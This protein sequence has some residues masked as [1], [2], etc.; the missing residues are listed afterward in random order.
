M[1]LA[2]LLA[3]HCAHAEAPTVL[4]EPNRPHGQER[5]RRTLLFY[6]AVAGGRFDRGGP[7]P[8]GRGLPLHRLLLETCR[9]HLENAK[10]VTRDPLVIARLAKVEASQEYAERMADHVRRRRRAER[11]TDI[12]LRED[13]AQKALATVEALHDDVSR[14]P[15]RPG[16]GQGRGCPSRGLPPT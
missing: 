7:A 10:A 14:E 15:A 8:V 3:A 6:D 4:D 2:A 13:I 1:I 12:A 9:R 16:P 11:E 5:S